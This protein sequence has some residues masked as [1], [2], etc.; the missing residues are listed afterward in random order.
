MVCL[1]GQYLLLGGK[2][3]ITGGA[4]TDSLE[5]VVKWNPNCGHLLSCSFVGG[6]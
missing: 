1:V 6:G 3:V 2:L 5:P 4:T